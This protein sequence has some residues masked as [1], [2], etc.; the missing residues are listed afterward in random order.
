MTL[1]TP[2]HTEVHMIKRLC[3]GFIESRKGRG[4]RSVGQLAH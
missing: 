1:F 4:G 2:A 3:Q